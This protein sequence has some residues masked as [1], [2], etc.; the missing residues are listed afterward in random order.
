MDARLL[1]LRDKLSKLDER[2]PEISFAVYVGDKASASGK[3]ETFKANIWLD[4]E[5]K[6]RLQW[7]TSENDKPKLP[8]LKTQ[9]IKKLKADLRNSAPE[10]LTR[11]YNGEMISVENVLECINAL[12][13]NGL[14]FEL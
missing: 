12:E 9:V 2:S 5:S 3:V 1:R 13:E 7:T 8:E 14:V 11:G 4:R 10:Y 6:Y